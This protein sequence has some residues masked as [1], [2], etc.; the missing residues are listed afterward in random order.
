MSPLPLIATVRADLGGTSTTT[1]LP[2]VELSLFE[3]MRGRN[4]DSNC[5]RELYYWSGRFGEC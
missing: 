3:P 5:I 1:G 4:Y 2:A